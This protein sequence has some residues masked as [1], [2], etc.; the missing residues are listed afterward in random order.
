MTPP[1]A[2]APSAE[3]PDKSRPSASPAVSPGPGLAGAAGLSAASANPLL[4]AWSGPCG[5]LPPFDKVLPAHLGPALRAGME[6]QLDA[7]DAIAHDP[8][9]PTFDNTLAPLERSGRLLERALAVYGIFQSTLNDEAVQA[10]ER[11]LE[12]EL[13]AFRDRITQNERLFKRIAAVYETRGSSNLTPEQQRLSWLRYTTFVREGARLSARAKKRLSEINQQLASLFTRFSQN[14]LADENEIFLL[15]TRPAQLAGLP[16]HFIAGA[17]AE[18]ESRGF[19]GKWLVANTRSSVEPFLMYSTRRELREKV[20]RNFT[21]RGDSGGVR[22]NNVLVVEILALRAERATLL[23]YATHAHWRLE[24]TMART[25]QRALQ[26]MLAVWAPAVARVREEVADMQ[27][28]AP[29]DE[30]IQPWDYRFY[31]EKVRAARY[32]LDANQIKPYLQLEKLREGMFEV[33]RELFGIEFRALRAGPLTD[34]AA[35]TD[36]PATEAVALDSVPVYHPD[37]RVWSVLDAAGRVLGLWYFDPFARKGK[38]SGAW[39]NQYR[40]QERFAGDVPALVSNNANFVKGHAGAGQSAAPVL[41]DWNDAVTLFHEFGHALHGL[42]SNVQYPTLSGTNVARDYVEFPSQLLEHWLSVPEV[43][44]RFAV[45]YQTGEPIPSELVER[46]AR[47]SRFNQGFATVEYLSA[48]LIDMK[49][50][51]AGATQI[52][53]E[54]FEREALASLGMPRELVMRHRTPQF[55]HVFASDG[56]SAGY[57]SYLWADT[58]TADAWEAFAAAPGGAWDRPTAERLR[59]R[60]FSAGNT[61]DPGEAY[62]AFRGRDAGIEA[63]MRKRGFPLPDG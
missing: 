41:I 54:T 22:D 10:V 4:N 42:L 48:A 57:Y 36:A 3:K 18:A 51:M 19:K 5:G 47:S 2:N 43:L 32:D 44:S 15:I 50:H 20:W 7:L 37:V 8:A 13:A 53:P 31:A 21:S 61:V 55:A 27:A 52:D 23:G 49:L 17:A 6:Q 39:M 1:R 45:H 33:A 60:V 14:L 30:A 35:R 11:E 38:Q 25:P 12:P 59:E 9:P 29:P 40:S 63:L 16:D 56:Y 62:R 46:I 26:L 34:A 24:D 58:L 28:L